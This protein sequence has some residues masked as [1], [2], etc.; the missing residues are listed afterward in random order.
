MHPIEKPSATRLAIPKMTTVSLL[1][2][3]PAAPETTANVVIIPS[4]APYTAS[5]RYSLTTL[6]F[7]RKNDIDWLSIPCQLVYLQQAS[8]DNLFSG[9]I[10]SINA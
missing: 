4:F 1:K 5:S 7:L 2:V 10:K 9:T 8:L 6:D 3:A